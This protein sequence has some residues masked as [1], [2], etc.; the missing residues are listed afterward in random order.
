MPIGNDQNSS[1][2]TSFLSRP[3]R[4]GNSPAAVS[5]QPFHQRPSPQSMLWQEP[6]QRRTA[7]GNWFADRLPRLLK[8]G[9][10]VLQIGE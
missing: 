2:A 6:I 9:N 3:Q 7:G 10:L 5:G 1:L 4:Q 8:R